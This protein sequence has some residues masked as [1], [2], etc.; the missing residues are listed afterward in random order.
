MAFVTSK[1][2]FAQTMPDVSASGLKLLNAITA[3]TIWA[4]TDLQYYLGTGTALSLDSAFSQEFH[5]MFGAGSPDANFAFTAVTQNAFAA[6][7]G[8]VSLDFSQTFDASEAEQVIVSV[9]KPSS[10]T[11][12]FFEF[13]G[14][15]YKGSTSDSWS[16]G[17]FNSGLD[18]MRKAAELGGGQYAYWT[19]I[20][21]IGHSLGLKHTHSESTGDA[22]AVVGKYMD[23]EMY[24]VMSYNPASNANAYGHAVTMMALDVGALQALYGTE[25]YADANSTY[26]L[27]DARGGALNMTEGAVS[28]GRAYYC[29]WD[30]GGADTIR[31]GNSNSSVLI[32][33]NDATLNT[34]ADTS[35]IKAMI[36]ELR[37]T[38]FF[39]DL[40]TALQQEITDKWHHAGG[41]FSHV[42]TDSS[43]GYKAISGGF[44]IAHGAE[45]ENATGGTAS[46]LIIGNEG[47]NT[48][49]GAGGND[50]ILG[51]DG[52]DTLYGGAGSDSIDGGRGDDDLYGN[53]GAD[54]FVFSNG[55][56]FDV[57]FDFGKGDTIDLSRLT[58]F[59][60]Y[61]DLFNN[62]MTQ[63]GSS[64]FID[65]GTDTLELFHVAKADL[66]HSDFII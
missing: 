48:L 52:A 61:N 22:L 46:D 7:D 53:S 51:G 40:S 3:N 36:V 15:E 62:K 8:V 14:N 13:P 60:S 9:N 44:S 41:F 54:R 55:Y 38:N 16:L 57:I 1:P 59:K 25:T 19:V 39:K 26:T 2:N 65:V 18:Y 12:G 28:I 11:E 5:A 17:A 34:S 49:K 35:D 63:E 31:Y 24:S 10:D 42:L 23:N 4:E 32:N 27:L 20:H 64:T 33:L 50:T 43:A 47:A 6:I 66:V 37:V 45:I 30:S 58:G 21:E 29:I 56:G